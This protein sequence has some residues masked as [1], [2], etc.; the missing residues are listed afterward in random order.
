MTNGYPKGRIYARLKILK[1]FIKCKITLSSME[2]ILFILGKLKYLENL[3][4]L[5]WKK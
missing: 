4:T 1:Q 3:V 2:T 5:A